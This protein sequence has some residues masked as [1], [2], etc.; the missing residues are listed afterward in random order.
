MVFFSFVVLFARPDFS[1]YHTASQLQSYFNLFSSNN[2]NHVSLAHCESIPYVSITHPASNSPPPNIKTTE[3]QSES[4]ISDS[5]ASGS[6]K[7]HILINFG[8]HGRELI[9][10]E[11]SRDLLD[12]FD[13]SS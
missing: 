11:I 1:F 6:Q 8:E 3:T 5:S 13:F 10:S 9:S 4:E 2:P 7:I 12:M